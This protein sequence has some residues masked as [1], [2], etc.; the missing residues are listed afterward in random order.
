LDIKHLAGQDLKV[1]AMVTSVILATDLIKSF[2]GLRLTPY[3]CPS[4]KRTIGYGHV[5]Q[6]D[7]QH[8]EQIS[9]DIA[10]NLLEKDIARS[11]NCLHKNCRVYLSIEQEAALLSFIFN[12]GSGAFQASSLRQKLNREEYEP[13]ANEFPR[14]VYSRGIKLPGLIRRRQAEQNLFLAGC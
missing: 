5:V 11:K 6:P 10:K 1:M 12:C 8:Y 13:A 4:G 7:D 3:I 2:E 14:W 9:P